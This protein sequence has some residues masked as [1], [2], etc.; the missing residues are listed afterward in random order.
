MCG[1]KNDHA[2]V[3]ESQKSRPRAMISVCSAFATLRQK[4]SLGQIGVM[5]EEQL[6]GQAAPSGL[7]IVGV[8]LRRGAR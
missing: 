8:G 1:K 7:P 2:A 6:A 4:R 3:V 5:K